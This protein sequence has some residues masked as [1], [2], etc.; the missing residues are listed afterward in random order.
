MG[1][2]SVSAV[3]RR[4]AAVVAVSLV[5]VGMLS[6]ASA[7]GRSTPAGGIA[8][9]IYVGPLQPARHTL[10]GLD[11]DEAPYQATVVVRDAASLDEV[12]RVRSDEHGDF[13]VTLAPGLYELDPLTE[14]DPFPRA[15]SIVV[16]VTRGDY[17]D[18]LV[19]YDLGIR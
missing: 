5:V 11:G 16:E 8:G 14:T 19:L 7:W 3:R 2:R 17:T 12:A 13:R 6:A 15:R 18:A 9:R 4:T 1:R 10:P